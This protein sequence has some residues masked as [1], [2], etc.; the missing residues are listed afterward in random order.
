MAND[1]I[2]FNWK[3]GKSPSAFVG[4]LALFDRALDNRLEAAM[5]DAVLMVE[6]EAKGRAPVDT[7]TLR[8]SLASEVR[9]DVEEAV[10]GYVGSHVEYSI[11]QEFGTSKMGASPFLQPAIDAKRAEILARFKKAV[12][13]AAIAAGVR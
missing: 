7:G 1:T 6:R 2:E 9:T 12:H 10:K 8:A 13:E 4:K 5:D 11:H 3:R